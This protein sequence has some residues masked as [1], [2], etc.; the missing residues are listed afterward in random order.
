MPFWP[1]AR[2]SNFTSKQYSTNC[3]QGR[4]QKLQEEKRGPKNVLERAKHRSIPTT[5]DWHPWVDYKIPLE[6][7]LVTKT[8]KSEKMGGGRPRPLSPPLNPPMVVPLKSI[9]PRFTHSIRCL[10]CLFHQFE[11]QNPNIL[12]PCS[13]KHE[14]ANSTVNGGLSLFL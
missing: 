4:F 2:I 7:Q 5:H 10:T 6:R 1:H 13:C 14:F 9:E 3:S 12:S 8:K 11:H